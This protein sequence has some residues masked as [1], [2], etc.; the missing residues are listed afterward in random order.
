MAN[1]FEIQTLKRKSQNKFP[2]NNLTLKNFG[3]YCLY[4]T[5][6]F[7]I[8]TF[9]FL[10]SGCGDIN[11]EV[12]TLSVSPATATVGIN[13]SYSFF[14][15]AKNS[16]G[17]D[18]AIT[19]TWSVTGSIGSITSNGFFTAGATDA[20]GEVVAAYNALTAV[21]AVTITTKG[22][23]SGTIKDEGGNLMSGLKVWLNELPNYADF[24]IA[25]GKYSISLIPPGTYEVDVAQGANTFAA[26]RE[27][28]ITPGTTR[29]SFDFTVSTITPTTS[30]TTPTVAF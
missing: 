11:G 13:Q 27:V 26:S 10:L 25:S 16:V 4:I 22:W 28:T 12:S 2:K 6:V 24:T 8:L 20:T 21:S 19:P 1:L 18:V 23:L 7:W 30:T 3:I 9:G 17:Q 15:V 29:S 14:I 5:F